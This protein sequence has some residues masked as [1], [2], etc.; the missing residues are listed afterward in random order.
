MREKRRDNSYV[1][2]RR[3]S[4]SGSNND[5]GQGESRLSQ[6][7]LGEIDSPR[8][9]SFLGESRSFGET[10]SRGWALLTI[11]P[12]HTYDQPHSYHSPSLCLRRRPLTRGSTSVYLLSTDEGLRRVLPDLYLHTRNNLVSTC[13]SR[14][15]G[16]QAQTHSRTMSHFY[17]TYEPHA[18]FIERI[19]FNWLNGRH[20]RHSRLGPASLESTTRSP[21]KYP[22]RRF[23]LKT[24]TRFSGI[25]PKT[26]RLNI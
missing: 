9:F 25:N 3:M 11:K 12:R 5:S 24:W 8:V 23:N 7:H 6:L 21:V 18:S 1:C 17:L 13:H 4:T 19:H 2:E 22:R 15:K 10:L 16:I 20:E 14:P 26:K